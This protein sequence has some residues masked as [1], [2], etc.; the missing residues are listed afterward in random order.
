MNDAHAITA[1]NMLASLPPALAGDE[2]LL[3][4]AT[5]IS[6][7]L[8]DR[9]EEIRSVLIYPRIDELPEDLLD[10]LAKDFK[11]DWWDPDYSVEEKR[12][13]LK[14]SWAVHKRLGTKAAVERAVS[15]IFP[16]SKVEEWF[17]Y[18]GGQPYHFRVK[19]NQA[20]GAEDPAKREGVLKRLEYYKN[21]RSHLDNIIYGW[22]E[23]IPERGE[24]IDL[25]K[26]LARFR[27]TNSTAPATIFDGSVLF[28]GSI[29]WGDTGAASIGFPSFAVKTSFREPED[30]SGRILIQGMYYW[31]G[32]AK[33]NGTRHFNAENKEEEI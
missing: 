7:T 13:V 33:F 3:A 11:V 22:S 28:D 19:I 29:L 9:V 20:E 14:S 31:D 21:L 23:R 6:Q 17:E 30:L 5:A 2:E 27:L 26:F 15:A 24:V 12:R 1:K 4:L 8:A 32:S 25:V 18:E 10:I 16:D